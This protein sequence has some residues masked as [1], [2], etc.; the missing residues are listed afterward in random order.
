MSSYHESRRAQGILA[1]VERLRL[2]SS[3]RVTVNVVRNQQRNLKTL[4]ETK[5]ALPEGHEHVSL[6]AS[7]RQ[8]KN[9]DHLCALCGSAVKYV[10]SIVMGLPVPRPVRARKEEFRWEKG[11]EKFSKT[12]VYDRERRFY[13]P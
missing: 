10:P 3:K 9:I 8:R 12:E 5:Q 13:H 7:Q 1:I 4:D 11:H 2:R 6:P